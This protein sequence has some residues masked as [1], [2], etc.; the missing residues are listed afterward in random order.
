LNY[1]K[2]DD[3]AHRKAPSGQNTNETDNKDGKETEIW[4]LLARHFRDTRH[5][6]EYIALNVQE[7]DMVL[8]DQ[9]RVALKVRFLPF[10]SYLWRSPSFNPS[11]V[12]TNPPDRATTQTAH[13]LSRIKT[14]QFQTYTSG[15]F[16][17]LVCY[18]GQFDQ[19]G[20]TV[21]ALAY[22]SDVVVSWD[23]RVPPAKYMQKV[24]LEFVLFSTA[25]D[26]CQ[27]DG[28][29]AHKT[30]GGNCT[31]PTYMVNL[32]Y[33]LRVHNSTSAS[34][35]KGR[36]PAPTTTAKHKLYSPHRALGICR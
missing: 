3:P 1:Q 4:V 7:D 22:S 36:A 12:L 6:N 33:H 21:T 34:I 15:S 10:I 16:S 29:L 31:H 25:A 5:T 2:I 26:G 32:Q 28:V 23:T 8:G 20:F 35:E 11:A 24:P 19:V 9:E 27:I 18:E 30:A 14:S 17:L 13:P